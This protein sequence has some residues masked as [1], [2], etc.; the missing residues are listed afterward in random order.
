M[1]DTVDGPCGPCQHNTTGLHCERCLPGHYGNPVQGSCKPCACPLYLPSNNFSPNCALASA[2]GDD[3]VCTQCPDG[4]TG[5]RCEL[6]DV[7]YWGSPS[8][9]GGSCQ[10]CACGGAPC[11]S[12]TGRCLVCPPHT[13]GARCDQCQEG[14]WL[15][16]AGEECVGCECGRGALSAACDARTGRCACAPGWAGR[17][18]DLCAPGHGDVAAGCPLCRC[19]PAARGGGCDPQSGACECA[20]GAAPPRCDVCLPAH[21]ALGGQGCLDSYAANIYQRHVAPMSGGLLSPVTCHSSPVTAA[22]RVM[23]RRNP[24]AAIFIKMPRVPP[25]WIAKIAR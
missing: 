19:G 17:A 12:D 24:V 14:Y 21:Y 10:A 1:L 23:S 13:E 22:R 16:G 9:A 11:D 8:T 18:C 2:E 6:C 4:Y 7:G 3:F 25:I 5:D 15:G 20:P